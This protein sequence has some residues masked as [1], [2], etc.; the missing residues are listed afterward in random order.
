[1]DFY[2]REDIFNYIVINEGVKRINKEVD[3]M[4]EVIGHILVLILKVKFFNN[5]NYL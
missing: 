5:L 4:G 2:T 3:A 1:M